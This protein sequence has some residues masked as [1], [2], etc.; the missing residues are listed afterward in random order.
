MNLTEY[1]KRELKTF[2]EKEFS[3]VDS[4]VLSQ[5]SYLFFDGI[6]PGI[7]KFK[8]DVMIKDIYRA[9]HF[10]TILNLVRLPEEN[11]R[12]LSALAASPRFR[13]IKMNY[14]VNEIDVN[15]ETQ[16]SAVSYVIDSKTAYIAFRGTGAKAVGWKEDFNMAFLDEVPAQRRAKEYVDTVARK[17]PKSIIVGGHSKGGNL[18]VYSAAMCRKQVQNR[19][20]TVFSHDG[21]GFKS[22]GGTA[23]YAAIKERIKKTVPQSAVIGMMLENQ[24]EFTVIQSI[25]TGIMQH[26]PFSWEIENGSFVKLEDITHSAKLLDKSLSSWLL[27]LSDA[28]RARFVDALYKAASAEEGE[29]V[30]DFEHIKYKDIKT[31]IEQTGNLEPETRRFLLGSI[32]DLIKL[33]IKTIRQ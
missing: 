3:E 8:K 24:K 10:E 7:D 12:L 21:P 14:Y 5:F 32:R 26:D 2:K 18:A 13:E 29:R 15:I 1:V 27:T 19:I 30:F 16:F 17:L 22:L 4:L 11:L 6:V 23:Q 20:M 9:E 31:F 33:S 25:R 28:D